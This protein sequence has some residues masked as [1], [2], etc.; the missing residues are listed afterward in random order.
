LE[1][2]RGLETIANIGDDLIQIRQRRT[3]NTFYLE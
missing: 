1:E 3:C 2:R